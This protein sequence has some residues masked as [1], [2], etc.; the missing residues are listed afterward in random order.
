MLTVRDGRLC[1]EGMDLAALAEQEGTPL[2]VYS[3]RAIRDT[4]AALRAAFATRHADTRIYY[5]SKACSN[6]W[7]LNVVRDAGIDVEVNSGGELLKALRAGFTPEQ[8][9]FNGV[10]K[11]RDE[12]ERALAV[13]VRALIVDSLHEL[14]RIAA[15]AGALQ[16]PAPVAPR[17][18]VGVPA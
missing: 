16:R 14:R 18:D 17:I 4:V 6:L 15:V 12:I 3:E 1:L 13:G 10:A 9:V 5:A 2:F 11:T 7:V 8:I